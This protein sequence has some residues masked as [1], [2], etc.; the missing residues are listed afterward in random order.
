[1]KAQT[2]TPAKRNP[3]EQGFTVDTSKLPPEPELHVY[4]KNGVIYIDGSVPSVEKKAEIEKTF[5][6]LGPRR[7]EDKLAVVSNSS[8]SM[9]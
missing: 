6:E 9:P 1:M 5:R 7:I 3:L 4:I 2:A 8:I